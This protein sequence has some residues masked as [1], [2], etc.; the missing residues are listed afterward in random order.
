M[1]A[2]CSLLAMTALLSGCASPSAA[3]PELASAQRAYDNASQNSLVVRWAPLELVRAREALELALQSRAQRQHPTEIRH[4]ASLAVQQA[5]VAEQV[6]SSR[7]ADERVATASQERI[8]LLAE[9]RIRSAEQR[10]ASLRRALDAALAAPS[11]L[12]GRGLIVTL[13]S[14]LFRFA[15]ADLRPGGLSTVAKLA[16]VLQQYPEYLVLVEGHTDSRGLD[17]RNQILSERRAESVRHA[18]IRQQIDPGRIEARGY[19]ERKPIADNRSRAGR[20][21]NRRVEVLIFK[22]RTPPALEQD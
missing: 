21:L 14:V 20:L 8:R 18:L 11:R 5:A 22:G 10:A 12:T 6:A 16:G 2:I 7:E 17:A 13:D 4:L 9:A 3:D 15:G 1:N 19:G